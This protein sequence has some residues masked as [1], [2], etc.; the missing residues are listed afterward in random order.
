MFDRL[1]HE[2]G[3]CDGHAVMQ[4]KELYCQMYNYDLSAGTAFLHGET[5]PF[6]KLKDKDLCLIMAAV[7]GHPFKEEYEC[8]GVTNFECDNCGHTFKLDKDSEAVQRIL[9]LL[10]R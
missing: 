7:L 10:S 4:T 9:D 3:E 1:T 2:C 8:D 6:Y 5:K